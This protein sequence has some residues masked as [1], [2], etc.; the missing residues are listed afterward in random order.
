MMPPWILNASG[1]IHLLVL[2]A[3]RANESVSRVMSR[4]YVR[5]GGS[6]CETCFFPTSG[7]SEVKHIKGGTLQMQELISRLQPL[8]NRKKQKVAQC[9]SCKCKCCFGTLTQ[10]EL[11]VQRQHMP[12]KFACSHDWFAIKKTCSEVYL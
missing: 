9:Q 2:M 8:F 3:L 5:T 11:W 1:K 7:A 6:L 10:I 12:C 4:M